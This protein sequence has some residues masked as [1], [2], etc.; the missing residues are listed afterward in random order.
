MQLINWD[1]IKPLV[2]PG[3]LIVM[4]F[5]VMLTLIWFMTVDT[6][7]DIK[8][9]SNDMWF[10]AMGRTF[11]IYFMFIVAATI[12]GALNKLVA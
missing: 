12:G 2:M 1:A 10:S 3:F 7:I 8:Y 6:G 4:F 5:L 11:F 9:L